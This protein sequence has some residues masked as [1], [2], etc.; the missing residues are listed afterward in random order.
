[1]RTAA[2]EAGYA[3]ERLE[4]CTPGPRVIWILATR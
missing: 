2:L 3:V 1:M 4:P